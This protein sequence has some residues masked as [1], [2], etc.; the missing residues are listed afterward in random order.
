MCQTEERVRGLAQAV[1]QVKSSQN[2]EGVW[3]ELSTLHTDVK[4]LLKDRHDPRIVAAAPVA[5]PHD[6]SDLVQP[7]SE[8][9]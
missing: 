9:V 3:R 4:L 2:S 6:V 7:S 5:Q 1:D 8:V